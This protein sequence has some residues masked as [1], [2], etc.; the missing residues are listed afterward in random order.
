MAPT[1][2]RWSRRRAIWP[3]DGGCWYL[4]RI[5]GMA[6]A[7]ELLWTG[8]LFDAREAL[9]IGYVSAIV[10]QADLMP[11]TRELALRLAR[12]PAIA[13]Q[14]IKRLAYRG[15]Q[16]G[17]DEALEAAQHAQLIAQSTEDALEGPRAFVE[18]R[19][20]QFKGR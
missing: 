18:K 12:G 2:L 11:Y 19:E 1:S 16:T 6:K 9:R 5:V 8:D 3:G 15:L 4:P 17:L 13:I 20:P 10:P 14:L 7:L